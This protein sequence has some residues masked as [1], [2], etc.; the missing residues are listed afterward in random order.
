[1]YQCANCG[2]K[3][4]PSYLVIG[5]GKRVCGP[6]LFHKETGQLTGRAHDC[7]QRR[8]KADEEKYRVAVEE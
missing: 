2:S 1:V 4:G 7:V 8:A 5:T 6:V 3:E